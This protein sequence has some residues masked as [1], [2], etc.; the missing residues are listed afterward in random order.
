MIK[1][2]TSSSYYLN[3][4][5]GTINLPYINSNMLSAG[6]VRFNTSTTNLEVYDGISWHR[7]EEHAQIDLTLDAK[8]IL[9]WARKKMIEEQ[10]L[11]ELCKKY[12]GLEKAKTNF[13][14]FKK[15]VENQEN[16]PPG[17]SGM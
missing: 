11:D 12:P 7:I 16:Y 14:T 15:M 5:G 10:R 9:D 13:E 8:E 4:T 6:Q 2:L 17:I 1:S 3:V